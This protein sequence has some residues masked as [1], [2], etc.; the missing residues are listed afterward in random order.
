MTKPHAPSTPALQGEMEDKY[1]E[2]CD[3]YLDG[4]YSLAIQY[5]IPA[6]DAAEWAKHIR[7]ACLGLNKLVARERE[8]RKQAETA[9]E[10]FERKRGIHDG[11]HVFCCTNNGRCL[12]CEESYIAA[13][14]KLHDALS[15]PV[16]EPAERE[17]GK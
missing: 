1:L 12:R 2:A 6:Q 16:Q 8:S 4:F 17:R 15:N 9:I 14:A 10:E 13:E 11:D 7:N 5:R 3:H